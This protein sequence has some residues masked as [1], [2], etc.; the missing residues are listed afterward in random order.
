MWIGGVL[1]KP[2]TIPEPADKDKVAIHGF[3]PKWSFRKH[4]LDNK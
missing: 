2:E 3:D 1:T 4:K